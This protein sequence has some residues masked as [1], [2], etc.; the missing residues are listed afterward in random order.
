MMLIKSNSANSSTLPKL[1]DDLISKNFGSL[2]SY[3][4]SDNSSTIP[5]ANILENKEAFIVEMVAPGLSKK[6]I[7]V[8]PDHETL[9][10]SYGAKEKEHLPDA[11]HY[12]RREYHYHSFHRSFYLPKNA[13]DPQGIQAKFKDGILQFFLP[14]KEEAKEQPVRTIP[15]K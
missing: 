1:F 9:H 5:A 11:V 12:I 15:I 3:H 7:T 8:R 4:L 14:K 6:G 13:V 10:I 2:D